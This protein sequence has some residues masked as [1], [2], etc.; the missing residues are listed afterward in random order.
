MHISLSCFS[1]FAELSNCDVD[2]WWFEYK[3][4]GTDSEGESHQ[5]VSDHQ[6]YVDCAMFLIF[7]NVLNTHAL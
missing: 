1:T 2:R 3:D 5:I 7:T 6:Q 4:V